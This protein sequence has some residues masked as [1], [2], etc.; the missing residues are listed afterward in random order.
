MSNFPFNTFVI[1][2]LQIS[3]ADQKG[4][5]AG[6]A[7]RLAW[8]RKTRSAFDPC[9]A[10]HIS[11]IPLPVETLGGWHA[12]VEKHIARLG[13]ELACSTSG[14]DQKT[15]ISHLFQRLSLTL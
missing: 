2:P 4:A 13:R 5:H 9:S 14:T 3:V 10:Q 12:E 15:S 8:E 11:F 1:F 7:L 6:Y